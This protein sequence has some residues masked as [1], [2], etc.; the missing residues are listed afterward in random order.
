LSIPHE[1]AISI[2]LK[3]EGKN[4]TQETDRK[5]FQIDY[6]YIAGNGIF[7]NQI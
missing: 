2:A 5:D 3:E 7:L 4:Y 6:V 1:A